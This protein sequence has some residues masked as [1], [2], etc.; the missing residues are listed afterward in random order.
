MESRHKMES[1][2][3]ERR[4][5]QKSWPVRNNLCAFIIQRDRANGQ[6]KKKGENRQKP[7]REG[8]ETTDRRQAT[9]QHKLNWLKS[10]N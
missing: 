5:E 7:R 4:T 2:G 10:F 6:Y 9:T 8:E 1:N 3:S